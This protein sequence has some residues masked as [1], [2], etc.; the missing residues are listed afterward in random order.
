MKIENLRKQFTIF[1]LLKDLPTTSELK[2]MISE[3]GYDAYMFTDQDMLISRISQ[4]PPHMILFDP[5]ALLTGLSNFVE[6]IHSLSSEVVFFSVIAAQDVPA[7]K[8]YKAFNFAN[9]VLTGDFFHD[10]VIWA[11]DQQAEKLYQV[12]LNEKI[13]ENLKEQSLKLEKLE[14]E[15]KKISEQTVS[16]DENVFQ[17]QAEKYSQLIKGEQREQ[18][19]H[20]FLDSVNLKSVY[21]KYLPSVNSFAALLSHQCDISSIQGQTLSVDTKDSSSLKEELKK[22]K[23]PSSLETLLKTNFNLTNPLVY[24]LEKGKELEGVFLFFPENISNKQSLEKEWILFSLHHEKLQLMKKIEILDVKDSVTGLWNK[25]YFKEK[26]YSEISRARRLKNPV[27]ILHLSL[28]KSDELKNQI[29]VV[30]FQLVLKAI[31]DIVLKI[32]RAHDVVA[33]FDENDFMILLPHAAVKNAALVA[34]RIRRQVEAHS[35]SVNALKVTV[36]IGISEFPSLCASE[37]DLCDTATKALLH[38][39]KSGNRLCIFKPA[40][41]FVPE[42]EV[43]SAL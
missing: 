7:M 9:P 1:V 2:L 29:G 40:P 26:C 18:L 34:E 6:A 19:V 10:R 15:H 13:Y 11:L 3:A 4:L 21:F 37:L 36:C 23:L 42:F 30:G 25:I 16:S 5:S 43:S 38:I 12:Y 24:T 22:N 39:I 20:F 41:T 8:A 14:I 32:C 28:D 35:F 17:H 31:A 33:R 27:S